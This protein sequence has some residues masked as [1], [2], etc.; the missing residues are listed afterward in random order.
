MRETRGSFESY[1]Q[2]FQ[3]IL[4]SIAKT[5]PLVYQPAF[6]GD[7]KRYVGNCS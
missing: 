5:S 4:L 7:L 6:S 1:G 3:M 2:S